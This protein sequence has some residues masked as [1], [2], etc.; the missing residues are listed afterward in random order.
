[1]KPLAL[2]LRPIDWIEGGV[3]LFAAP[4]LIFPGVSPVATLLALLALVAAW[5]AR[6]IVERQPGKLTPLNGALLLWCAAVGVG[7][8]VTAFPELT[9]PKATGLVLGL[10][11]CRY[12][13]NAIRRRAQLRWAAIGLVALGL[14]I[15]AVGVVSVQWPEKVPL[16]TRRITIP[17]PRLLALPGGPE[18]GISANQFGGTLAFFI[19]LSASAALGA[20]QQRGR[21]LLAVLWIGLSLVSLFLIVLTQSR[22]AWLGTLM[23]GLLLLALWGV[24]ARSP[25]WRMGLLA[26][27]AVSLLALAL[28][29]WWIGAERLAQ[30]WEEPG[31]MTALGSLSTLGFRQEVWRWAV[32]ALGDFP[33]TGCGL[34]TFREVVRLL[35]PLNVSPSFDI[36]HAHNIFLQVGLDVGLPGLIAYLA[37]LGIAVAVGLQTAHRDAGLRPLALGLVGGLASLHIYGLLD[38]L[39][40]GS[41]TAIVFWIALGLLGAM[42]CMSEPERPCE[43]GM[44]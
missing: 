16:I 42:A 19:A 2:G 27:C 33:F 3:L 26:L 44:S 41:K 11:T 29:L 6:W 30:I 14:A 21:R 31:G 28:G 39:A 12:L 17:M 40:P 32:A 13:L 38:A 34:G 22:G 23:G 4:F 9:L 25:G 35:Y 43:E 8:L 1:M 15:A 5:I 18:S 36:A 20:L 37:L 24:Y 7:I 10:A